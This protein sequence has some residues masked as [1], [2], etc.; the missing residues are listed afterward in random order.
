MWSGRRADFG[1]VEYEM[2]WIDCTRNKDSLACKGTL[3]ISRMDFSII[4]SEVRP[5]HNHDQGMH[6]K[7]D[8]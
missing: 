5:H 8:F 1:R 2:M 6:F 4:L 7:N 3:W